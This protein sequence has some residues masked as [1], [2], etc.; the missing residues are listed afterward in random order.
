VRRELQQDSWLRGGPWPAG[1]RDA[2]ALRALE[3]GQ[4]DQGLLPASR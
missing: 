3:I 1:S 2:V 4:R